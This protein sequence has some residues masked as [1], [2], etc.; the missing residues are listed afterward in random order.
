MRITA[1]R[2]A[3]EDGSGTAAMTQSDLTPIDPG[4]LGTG[5]ELNEETTMRGSGIT[6]PSSPE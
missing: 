1:H 3:K 4:V 5:A 2:R 6:V